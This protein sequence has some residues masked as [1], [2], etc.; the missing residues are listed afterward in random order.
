MSK[1]HWS[2][3]KKIQPKHKISKNPSYISINYNTCKL[4]TTKEAKCETKE[5]R[6]R[7]EESYK[8][9]VREGRRR[10]KGRLTKE[11]KM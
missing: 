3:Q 1:F 9:R 2:Q 6:R 10:E 7:T 5:E 4:L 11:A 8:K